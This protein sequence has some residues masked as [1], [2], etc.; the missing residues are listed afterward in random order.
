MVFSDLLLCQKTNFTSIPFAKRRP[1][2]KGRGRDSHRIY[3]Q[4][5]SLFLWL[6]L[7]LLNVIDSFGKRTQMYHLGFA[8]RGV[9]NWDYES[10]INTRK[11]WMEYWETYNVALWQCFRITS[12]LDYWFCFILLYATLLCFSYFIWILQWLQI[13]SAQ[14]WRLTNSFWLLSVVE[15]SLR[16]CNLLLILLN[17][18]DN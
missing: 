16:L 3:S 1:M 5:I 4:T 18:C 15:I 12:E 7:N 6:T 17:V 11:N 8:L 14:C 2:E 9:A 13:H 10:K